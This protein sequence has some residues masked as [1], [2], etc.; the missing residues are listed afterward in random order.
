VC[1]GAFGTTPAFPGE[2]ILQIGEKKRV[3]RRRGIRENRRH[4]AAYQLGCEA[5]QPIDVTVGPAI[6]N[7]DIA[8]LDVS[9]FLQAIA[10]CG[11]IKCL[12]DARRTTHESDDRHCR[13]LRAHSE[14]PCGCRSTNQ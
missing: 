11:G 5:R 10:K 14:R 8:V 12:S 1:F 9:A 3:A 7:G 4:L 6:F 13:L 2:V